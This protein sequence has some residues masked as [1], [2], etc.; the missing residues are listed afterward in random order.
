[1]SLWLDGGMYLPDDVC[2]LVSQPAN[3][4]DPRCAKSRS[5]TSTSCHFLLGV[6]YQFGG[7]LQMMVS[8]SGKFASRLR[9]GVSR[10]SFPHRR[11]LDSQLARL[12]LSAQRVGDDANLYVYGV[13]TARSTVFILRCG[14]PVCA[15]GSWI[16]RLGMRRSRSLAMGLR[17]VAAIRLPTVSHARMCNGRLPCLRRCGRA[18]WA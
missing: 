4:L 9:L 5:R 3:I 12:S 17:T 16:G 18:S 11:P 2:A 1:M 14:A 6:S 15:A 13:P 7:A 10:H 8:S